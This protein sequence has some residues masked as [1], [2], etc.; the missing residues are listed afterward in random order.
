MFANFIHFIIVLLLHVSYQPTEATNWSDSESLVIGTVAVLLFVAYCHWRY[1]KV[2]LRIRQSDLQGADQLF[3]AN[4]TRL[5]I[6][7]VGL[8][9]LYIYGL[10]LPSFLYEL[11]ILS[12][13]PTFSALITLALF[14]L[15]LAII[16]SA[17][18]PG[19]RL[20]YDP[21][22]TRR[23]YI[24]SN[25]TAA[26]PLLFPWLAISVLSDLLHA[27]PVPWLQQ[28]LNSTWG[29]SVYFLF[30]L[31]ILAI[32]APVFIQRFWGC[33]PLPAGPDR[34]RIEALCR[35]AGI[36]YAQILRWPLFGGR[37]IT[38]GVM[39][40]VGRF[41]Y[42]LVTDALLNHLQPAEIDA[43]IAHEIGHV[44]KHHLVFYLVFLVGY[45]LV[46]FALFDLAVFI[47]L[48]SKPIQ[49][50]AGW[51]AFNPALLS[52]TLFSLLAVIFFV[53]Y[54]RFLFGFF[55]RNFERQ[56]D[57][58]VYQLVD[59]A[60]PLITTLQKIARSSRQDPNRPNWHHFSI[61]ERI[62]YLSKCEQ[63][64]SWVHR[65]DC[66]IKKGIA[67][68]LVG[69]IAMGTVGW[70]LNFGKAGQRINNHFFEKII[71][72][73][74][75]RTP[76]NPNLLYALGNL[77]Y[78]QQKWLEAEYLYRQALNGA[79]NNPEILNNLA[80][81]YATSEISPL[82][83]PTLALELA[84]R[85]ASLRPESPHILDTLAEAYYVNDQYQE[86]LMVSEK[87]LE[88]AVTNRGYYENQR[89]KFRAAASGKLESI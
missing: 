23:Q 36:Q 79:P 10:N 87:A 35:K 1:R 58:Y 6:L 5:K 4:E 40:L 15:H 59:S 78:D 57:T 71:R 13:A 50:M 51:L 61:R 25:L 65:Q 62:D 31:L 11:P 37:M 55:M 60:I 21:H 56:A 46:S 42:I 82:Q 29:Q 81:L 67:L 68:F 47:I 43:V 75:A 86:A 24:G 64:R 12:A 39:G 45:M 22:S 48:Y 2:W 41:R 18:Y 63:D 17:A 16:W 76:D 66:K 38:A 28:A 49:Q 74:L 19:Y 73:E 7:A 72:Q 84:Q 83:A 53:L 14:T 54:F 89:N 88:Q 26:A 52:S 77:M 27:L 85:A 80:W 44:K 69:L 9:A 34:Q 33:T 30:F 70:Q 32:F 8:Q 3:V 20:L